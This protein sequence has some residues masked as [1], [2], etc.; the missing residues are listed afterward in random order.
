MLVPELSSPANDQKPSLRFDGLE[1]F[2]QS[3]RPG[4]VGIDLWVSTRERV[5]D[6][7]STP[8]NLGA[9]VNSTSADQGAYISADGQTLFFTSNRPGGFGG[10]DLYVTTRTRNRP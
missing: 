3:D 10:F 2:F 7:W 5:I 4:S 1:M 8:V 9:T 6:P